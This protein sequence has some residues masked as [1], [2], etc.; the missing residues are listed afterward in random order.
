MANCN[1]KIKT[2]QGEKS[3]FS[4]EELTQFYY[5]SNNQLTNGSI[6]SSEEIIESTEN[7]INKLLNNTD[8]I[9]KND[10]LKSTYEF[11]GEKNEKMFSNLGINKERLNPEYDKESRIIN[12]ILN[13]LVGNGISITGIEKALSVSEIVNWS[14]YSED[15]N[16][17]VFKYKKDIEEVILLEEKTKELG[18]S[19]HRILAR[20]IT[21]KGEFS[22]SIENE[23]LKEL[24]NN[25]DILEGDL[26]NWVKLFEKQLTRIYEN[27][28]KQGKILSEVVVGSEKNAPAQIKGALDIIVISPDGA[29]HIYDLKLSK[30]K[31]EDWDSAKKLTTDNQLALYRALMGQ[32]V[33]INNST[34]SVIPIEL[35][36]MLNGKLNIDSV[37]LGN[38][39][40]RSGESALQYKSGSIYTLVKKLI[41]EKVHISHDP[42]RRIKFE[43]HLKHILPIDYEIRTSNKKNDVEAMVDKAMRTQSYSISNEYG[44][45]FEGETRVKDYD[46]KS[47]EEI[48]AELTVIIQK[49]I[50]FEESIKNRNLVS[51]KNQIITSITG[52]KPVDVKDP[53]QNILLANTLKD[54]ITGEYEVIDNIEELDSFGFILLQNKRTS[55]FVLLSITSHNKYASIGKSNMLYEEAEYLKSLLLFNNFKEDLDLNSTGIEDIVILNLEGKQVGSKTVDFY[56]E[57]FRNLLNNK[58]VPY[59]LE[60][61]KPKLIQTASNILRQNLR[62]APE[63]EKEALI[64]IIGNEYTRFEDIEIEKLKEILKSMAQTYPE[65]VSNLFTSPKLNFKNREEYVYALL[66]CLLLRKTRFNMSGDFMHLKDFSIGFSDIKSLL[67]SLYSDKQEE[68]DATA[69]KIMGLPGGLKMVTPDRVGSQVLQDI[70]G[71]ITSGH[72][73]YAHTYNK[74]AVIFNRLTTKFAK[75]MNYSSFEQNFVGD[76]QNLFRNMWFSEKTGKISN[77]WRVKN[78]YKSD[79]DNAMSDTE[80][81]YLKNIL[82]QIRR[83]TEKITDVDFNKIDFSTLETIRN[84]DKTGKIIKS[85]EDGDYFLM[86]LIRSQQIDRNKDSIKSLTISGLKDQIVDNLNNLIDTRELSSDDLR[87]IKTVHEGLTEMYDVYDRRNRNA[88]FIADSVDESE[89]YWELDLDRIAN[90]VAFSSIRKQT[91]DHILPII[92]SAIWYM[93]LQ[94]G[95]D[96]TDIRKE[97]DYIEK[98]LSLSVMDAPIVADEAKDIIL[99]TSMVKRF[100][101]AFM[102]GLRPVLTAKEFAIGLYK[103]ISLA[104]TKIYGK[105]QFSLADYTK[106]MKALMTIDNQYTQEFNMIDKINHHYRFANMDVNAMPE[107]LK[108]FRRGAMLGLGPW[109]YSTSTFAD[110]SNRLSLFIAKMYNDGSY[111]AHILVNGELIYDPTKD[112]RFEYYFQN[113]DKYINQKNGEYMESSTDLKFNTQRNVYLLTMRQINDENILLGKQ[114]LVE[115]DLIEYAYSEKERQ[116]YKSFTDSVYGYYDK[117]SQAEWHSTWYGLIFLQFLQF[118]PGKMNMWFGKPDSKQT[119]IGEM[120]HKTMISPT[121]GKKVPAFIEVVRDPETGEVIDTIDVEED[122]SNPAMVWTGTPQEGLI[123]AIGYTIQDVLRGNWDHIKDMELRNKRVMFAMSDT[124]IMMLI[125]GMIGALIDVFVD[126]NGTEGINGNTAQFMQEVNKKVLTE[127]NLWKNTLGAIKTEPAFFSFGTKVAGDIQDVFTGDKSIEKLISKNIKAFELWDTL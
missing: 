82:S 26:D 14:K 121:T 57:S 54:Y 61:N 77:E 22:S 33:K 84:T 1:Y 38:I 106:A 87:N 96:N 93:K 69:K 7:I 36:T 126:E 21:N 59:T 90:K 34:M 17:K 68:Y 110:Y 78:P 74:Q 3:T 118:W 67:A 111:D 72:S 114:E 37:K 71:I 115:K 35:G 76:H 113:R 45:E 97:L 79:V 91:M 94:A 39:E 11:S 13:N 63:K 25:K 62:E 95:K 29:I 102:L 58:S 122:N 86:P 108:T 116:S 52:G 20:L 99:T 32:Y 120:L 109:M 2:V 5:K 127:T 73:S 70:N 125:F 24:E 80:R 41:P 15:V 31:Y 43:T 9:R 50:E 10:D 101:T 66:N 49:Y 51:L 30:N 4:L 105:N 65:L 124:L 103:G 98:R 56:W 88:K 53:D 19:I 100:T 107:K 42:E 23:L 18:N 28:S 55:K 75:D 83:H 112:K 119:N 117:D 104:A 89:S 60:R 64:N 27:L 123:Y 6:F 81:E 12:T 8:N 48:R 46:K 47:K 44:K 85:I 16:N 40:I 92:T